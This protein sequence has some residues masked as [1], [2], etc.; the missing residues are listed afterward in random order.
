M[1][2]TTTAIISATTIKKLKTKQT[3]PFIR[4]QGNEKW[5]FLAFFYWSRLFHAWIWGGRK[6]IQFLNW[7]I[8]NVSDFKLKNLKRLS[9]SMKN[10]TTFPIFEESCFSKNHFLNYSIPWKA[11][12]TNFASF[13]LF[14][15]AF[16]N[17]NFCNV[18]DFNLIFFS[19]CQILQQIFLTNQTLDW[20]RTV[21]YTK[22]WKKV[23]LK[24]LNS[25][26]NSDFW[27]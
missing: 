3:P 26:W 19:K 1:K 20:W 2:K 8:Y 17:L 9:F 21:F 23:E 5:T 22:N 6:K 15:E 4:Y 7:K 25:S 14:Q 13:V 24:N 12:M 11:K 10:C 18:S 27:T 16:P